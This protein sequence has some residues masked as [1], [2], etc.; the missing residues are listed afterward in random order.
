MNTLE[1]RLERSRY[2][3]RLADNERDMRLVENARREFE[4]SGREMSP[5][6][7]KFEKAVVNEAAALAAEYESTVK[8][9]DIRNDLEFELLQMQE[10][11]ELA[12]EELEETDPE[13]SAKI[14]SIFGNLG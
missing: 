7:L 13:K 6:M 2:A 1:E 14:R 12:T 11:I 8:L 4:L 9:V 10:R 3:Q 5:E